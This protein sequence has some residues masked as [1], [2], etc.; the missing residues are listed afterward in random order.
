MY[1]LLAFNVT[2]N[3]SISLSGNIMLTCV[4]LC[5]GACVRVCTCV[6]VRACARV[7]VHACVWSLWCMCVCGVCIHACM[8]AHVCVHVCMC[9]CFYVCVNIH[10]VTFACHYYIRS[11]TS[12]LQYAILSS[13]GLVVKIGWMRTL[14]K[15]VEKRCVH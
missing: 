7:C 13:N 4:C 12:S 1:L 5:L 15:V 3:G 10:V 8:D 9:L 11:V 6:C 14:R 2:S